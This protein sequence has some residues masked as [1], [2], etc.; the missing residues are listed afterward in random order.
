MSAN[1]ALRQT[2]AALL[3]AKGE[4]QSLSGGMG[5]SALHLPSNEHENVHVHCDGFAACCRE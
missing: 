2:S 3:K 5:A 1:K 4:V